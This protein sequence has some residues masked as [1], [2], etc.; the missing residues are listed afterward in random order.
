MEAR[1]CTAVF[2]VLA[3][4]FVFL[5]GS[6]VA[7]LGDSPEDPGEN[8]SAVVSDTLRNETGEIEVLVEI[9]GDTDGTALPGELRTQAE[10]SQATFRQ[11][12]AQRAG[13]T[14][15]NTFWITNAVLATVDTE[16]VPL[17]TLAGIDGVSR[18]EPNA[19]VTVHFS[20]F[21]ATQSREGVP[22]GETV[23]G[24]ETT[25]GLADIG[26]PAV[27]TEYDTRGAGVRVAVLD[28]GVDPEHPDI[29]L[30]AADSAE[31]ERWAEFDSVGE[32]VTG[33]T[34][35]D[36]HGHGTLVSGVVAGGNASGT[37]IGV[38]PDVELMHGLVFDDGSGTTAQIIAG[39]EWA[40]SN[41]A[42]IVSISGGHE[43]YNN[44]YMEAVQHALANGTLVVASSGNKGLST[45]SSPANVYDAVAVGASNDSGYVWA[46]SSGESIVTA[47]V[48]A[49]WSRQY[50][51]DWPERYTVPDV[52]A[53]GVSVPTAERGGGYRAATGT[54]L[55]APHVAGGLALLQAGTTDRLPPRT[56][57]DAL[58]STARIPAEGNTFPGVGNI[59]YGAGIIDVA[60]AVEEVE[61]GTLAPEF[62]VELSYLSRTTVETGESVQ[63][64]VSVRNDGTLGQEYEA[65]LTADDTVFDQGAAFIP[66]GGQSG[67]SLSATFERP[68]EYNLTAG[69][70]TVGTVVVTGENSF[71]W[72]MEYTNETGVVATGGLNTA[73][74]DYL[75]GELAESKLNAVVTSYL[76]GEPLEEVYTD[77]A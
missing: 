19:N 53:P 58:A 11:F 66:A 55:A 13:V 44:F 23:N 77:A 26:A 46:D 31:Y 39:I 62:N 12:A 21:A 30:S 74:K 1:V 52:V 73:I 6:P 33:S 60:A 65:N 25:S 47:D 51:H 71:D 9:R 61:N 57:V 72:M 10:E 29:E 28:T 18:I 5:T 70:H 69:N 7:G 45:S 3:L 35:R 24:V 2:L 32:R 68:G 75:G 40:V 48:W 27:W 34:P 38:T 54:S 63:V 42:D 36:T 56:L 15:E 16:R 20:E 64:V 76:R 43:E 4:L 22:A 49:D 41:D 17:E 50:W 14:V 8:V 67:V 37:H 59:R